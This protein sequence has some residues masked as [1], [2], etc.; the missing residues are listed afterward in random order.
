MNYQTLLNKAVNKLKSN[1]II[2]P[3]LDSELLLSKVLHTTREKLLLNLAKKTTSQ[4]KKKFDLVIE[5]RSRKK[6]LAYILGNK[7][8]WKTN[9]VVNDSVLIPRPDTEILVEEAT[10]R[11]SNRRL[12]RWD[13]VDGL[14]GI[15]NSENSDAIYFLLLKEDSKFI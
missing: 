2:N 4:E 14:K 6:P 9:F 5:K 8:F 15:L 10:K 7:E 12:A 3:G 11:L 1:S 13:Y